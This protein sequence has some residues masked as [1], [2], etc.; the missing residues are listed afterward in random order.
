MRHAGKKNDE[1]L[2]AG[3]RFLDGTKVTLGP[4]HEQSSP[5]RTAALSCPCKQDAR[6]CA[7]DGAR[8]QSSSTA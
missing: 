6:I 4:L 7:A 2:N 3:E 8:R 1:H 5:D